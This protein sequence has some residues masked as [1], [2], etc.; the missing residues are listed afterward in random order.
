MF[1]LDYTQMRLIYQK[2]DFNFPS[3]IGILIK[4]KIKLP[5]LFYQE[6]YFTVVSRFQ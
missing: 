3:T 1:R 6:V 2:I 4:F 5:N